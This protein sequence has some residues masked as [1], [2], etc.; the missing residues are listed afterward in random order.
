[1]R[2]LLF[3]CLAM[4]GSIRLF[5]QDASYSLAEHAVNVDGVTTFLSHGGSPPPGVNVAGFDAETG[6]GL[7]T[8]AVHGQGSHYVSVFVDHEIEESVNTFFNE[9]ASVSGAPA[10]GQTWEVDEPGFKSGSLQARFRDGTL[11]NSNNLPATS[12]DDVAMAMAWRPVLASDQSAVVQVSVSETAPA[13]GFYLSQTDALSHRTLFFSGALRIQNGDLEPPT[14]VC[15]GAMVVD[16]D[17]GQCFRS[18][19]I[20]SV[21]ATDNLP[22][23]SVSCQPPSGAQFPAGTTLVA[24]TATDQAGNTSTCSFH[25]TVRPPPPALACPPNIIVECAPP[26][27]QRVDFNVSGTGVCG[28]DVTISCVPPS[29]SLF[30]VGPTAV[31][32]T[33][34]SSQGGSAECNFAVL[35]VGTN[36]QG[37]FSLSKET[38]LAGEVHADPLLFPYPCGMCVQV[39]GVAAQGW[40]FMGWLGDARGFDETVV[41]TMTQPKCVE[42][43]FGTPVSIGATTHG[44][45]W[46]DPAVSLYPCGSPVRALARPD[47]GYYFDHWANALTGS[48]NPNDF[49][50][51]KTNLVVTPVFLPLNAG[52]FALTVETRGKGRVLGQ[53]RLLNRYAAGSSAVLRAVP[54]A[55]QVFNGWSTNAGG[56][57]AS[58]LVTIN[59]ITVKMTTNQLVTVYFTQRP[60]IEIFQ[61]EGRLA[62]G[63]FRFQVHG[64]LRD[65]YSIQA[66]P[67]LDDPLA[68]KE[69]ARATNTLGAVQY[70]DPYLPNVSQR[71]YRVELIEP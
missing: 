70:E 37:E 65:R 21:T 52:E 29:G 32:C 57:A 8:V 24:C 33:G 54:D 18:N 27:G 1:M 59:P 11:R 26:G 47:P 45:G 56:G 12:P 62:K 67:F 55:D 61:C 16:A 68:W 69:T 15:P 3:C 30:T 58:A 53:P 34:V 22:G 20:Y 38:C 13:S 66:S 63:L 46:L 50:L 41:L 9:F 36:C 19:V 5:G 43:V 10:Q 71:F 17:P 28:S 64:K 44:V 39:S 51:A 42:A 23:V 60:R 7:I 2:T 49:T 35:L 6:L 25:L 4:I 31:R 48:L 40:V 14:V